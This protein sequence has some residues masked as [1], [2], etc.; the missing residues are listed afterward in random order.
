VSEF[1]LL[2]H[3]GKEV[4]NIHRVVGDNRIAYNALAGGE[5]ILFGA[6]LVIALILLKDPPVKAL[7]IEA[8]ELDRSNFFK[9]ISALNVIAGGIDNIMVASCSDS[10][11]DAIKE[12]EIDELKP[13]NAVQL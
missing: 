10:V 8:A 11:C 5:E 13:W 12:G 3:N 1:Q 9:L 6:A 2:D 7:C 4:F